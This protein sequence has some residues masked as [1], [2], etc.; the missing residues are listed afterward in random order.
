MF[1]KKNKTVVVGQVPE[2]LVEK[3][4]EL[5]DNEVAIRNMIEELVKERTKLVKRG[6]ELWG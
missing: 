2:N 5:A 1:F 3:F 4:I 6:R